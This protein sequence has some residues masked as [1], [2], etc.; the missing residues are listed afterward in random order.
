MR[1]SPS[2]IHLLGLQASAGLTLSTLSTFQPIP[3]DGERLR[4]A[5]IR[6]P[7]RNGINATNPLAAEA[8][9]SSVSESGDGRDKD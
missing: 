3:Y 7:Y 8:K 4:Q 1:L 9:G 5:P 2:T 6:A